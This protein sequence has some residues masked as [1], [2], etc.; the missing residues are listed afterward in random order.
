MKGS[1][2]IGDR[3]EKLKTARHEKVGNDR[4]T[5]KWGEND[6]RWSLKERFSTDDLKTRWIWKS[7]QA[8]A[9]LL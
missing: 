9:S 8:V 6:M 4:A 7:H 2:K 5:G 1:K 3:R